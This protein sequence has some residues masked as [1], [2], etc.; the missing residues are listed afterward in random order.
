MA[1][2]VDRE[3]EPLALM[4]T[5][6]SPSDG[7][8]SQ[9]DLREDVARILLGRMEV[10]VSD[11]VTLVSISAPQPLDVEYCSRLVAVLVQLLAVGVR[12]G[13]VDGR[14][15]LVVDLYR[16]MAERALSVEGLFNF[17]YLTERAAL[18]EV[19][20]D[21][22]LGSST[23]AWPLASQLIGRASFDLLAAFSD[24]AQQES[25]AASVTDKLT[26]LHTRAMMGP[27]LVTVLQRAERGRWPVSLIVFDIDHL[28]DIN[29]TYGYGVGDR[30][31]ER[32]GI[33][34]RKY[35]RQEDWVF[36]HGDD[37]IA[38]LLAE[39]GTAD[40]MALARRVLDMVDERL[41]FRDHRS[42]SRVRVTVSAAV[43]GAQFV[44]G[45]PVDPDRMIFEA[46]IALER[47]KRAGRGNIESVDI[48]PRAVSMEIAGR[49][50][51]CSPEAA[52]RLLDD[53]LLKGTSTEPVM[54]TRESMDQYRLS[55]P[56]TPEH[57]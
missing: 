24:H 23:E 2:R 50:L 53:G 22:R 28:A 37:S 30:I 42:E 44:T 13:R 3:R 16:L 49:Y 54:I 34:M 38:V 32:M 40:A 33:Q 1:G 45:D 36:R 17:A 4:E 35:F 11:S 31:L 5:T 9:A 25:T 48:M 15:G 56:R 57:T 26:T 43:V 19:S 8:H 46:E 7:D 18:E 29:Q 20:L 41:K 6:F 51:D 14:S 12:E 47:A 21:D 55:Q 39:T 27:V 10:I 52:R